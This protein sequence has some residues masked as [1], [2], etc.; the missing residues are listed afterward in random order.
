MASRLDILK[1]IP[2]KSGGEGMK[3][4][5][6]RRKL[7][8]R[9]Q[10]LATLG[11]VFF[12]IVALGVPPIRAAS[13][14]QD[15]TSSYWAEPQIGDLASRGILRGYPDGSFRS[16]DPVTRAEGA[17]MLCLVLGMAP[18]PEARPSFSDLP[19]AQWAF[20]YVEAAMQGGWIH[21][22]PDGTFLP[23]RP[24]SKA[25]LLSM[26]ARGEGWSNPELSVQ[27]FAD[28]PVSHW[29]F[30]AVQ[31]CYAHEVVKPGE[32]H[33]SEDGLLQP[34]LAATRAQAAVFLDRALGASETVQAQIIHGPRLGMVTA[35]Q[36]T[37]TGTATS[38]SRAPSSGGRR[39]S[40]PPR[41]ARRRPQPTIT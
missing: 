9:H 36:A 24:V 25:E 28:V 39:P 21:G 26:I 14:F 20:P 6:K 1:V 29:A 11:I 17:K 4:M 19:S 18:Q 41:S 40:T 31:S 23:D 27:P 32:P 15:V 5:E 13:T 34:S 22:Y 16:E 35:S 38:P 7:M 8:K 30:P 12:S 10:I 37:I 2:T 33:L 3:R